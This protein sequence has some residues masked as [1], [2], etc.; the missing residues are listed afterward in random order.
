MRLP[1]ATSSS[2]LEMNGAKRSAHEITQKSYSR[3]EMKLSH[4]KGA[5]SVAFKV[6]PGLQSLANFEPHESRVRFPSRFFISS[7][8]YIV[9]RENFSV[10][11]AEHIII[12][13][14]KSTVSQLFKDYGND[15]T[16]WEHCRTVKMSE[17][18]NANMSTMLPGIWQW[19]WWWNYLKVSCEKEFSL[20]FFLATCEVSLEWVRVA[21]A[22]CSRHLGLIDSIHSIVTAHCHGQQ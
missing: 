8:Q 16:K 5:S 6:D 1:D 21:V 12:V 7:L 19:W 10:L 17:F 20:I 22:V 18:V 15:M 14:R 13:R 2:Q 9:W 3:K 4:P 11:F